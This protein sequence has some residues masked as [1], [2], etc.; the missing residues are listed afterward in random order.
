MTRLGRLKPE[1]SIL[2]AQTVAMNILWS[3]DPERSPEQVATAW[4]EDFA[5]LR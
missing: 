2:E 5:T 1:M 4:V 3:E